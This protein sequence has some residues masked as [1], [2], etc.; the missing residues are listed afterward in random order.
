MRRCGMN[1]D[2]HLHCAARLR[3]AQVVGAAVSRCAVRL[4]HEGGDAAVPPMLSR[5]APAGGSA[6]DRWRHGEQPCTNCHLCPWRALWH[7]WETTTARPTAP[8]ND[9]TTTAES[10]LECTVSRGIWGQDQCPLST[11]LCADWFPAGGG[12][13]G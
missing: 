7:L 13:G 8:R 5:L 3:E 4:P 1:H 6:G 2:V 9:T 11:V 12:G 10:S